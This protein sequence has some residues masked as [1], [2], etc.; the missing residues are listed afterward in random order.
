[1]QDE[2]PSED[3]QETNHKTT[4][5]NDK[6]LADNATDNTLYTEMLND[7]AVNGSEPLP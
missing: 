7:Y 2:G 3:D 1:M 4:N 5:G 6:V